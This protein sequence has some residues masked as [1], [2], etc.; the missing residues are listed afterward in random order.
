MNK[1]EEHRGKRVYPNLSF[2]GGI[3]ESFVAAKE[4]KIRLDEGAARY[5][6]G[7]AIVR[8]A[9]DWRRIGIRKAI[10]ETYLRDVYQAYYRN[11]EPL[12]DV[13]DEEFHIGIKWA[14][15][16]IERFHAMLVKS[17]ERGG[18]PEYIVYDYLVEHI[19]GK[20]VPIH[21]VAWKL[22]LKH[23][24]ELDSELVSVGFVAF[25][26]GF[27]DIAKR[28]GERCLAGPWRSCIQPR[29]AAC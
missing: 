11:L 16:P 15:Q 7:V 19:E 17:G 24:E 5:P 6:G 23:P 12:R 27:L 20:S 29:C 10:P 21:H 13:T 14:R 25:M 26:R 18:V 9:I 3:G 2:S 1:K 22:A 8:A 4:L 28:L